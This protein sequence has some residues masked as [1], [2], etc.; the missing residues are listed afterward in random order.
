MKNIRATAKWIRNSQ[1]EIHNHRGHHVICD[2]PKNQGGDN[3][4]PTA[5]EL[6]TMALAGCAVSI[7][8]DVCKQSK[9]KLNRLEV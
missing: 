8:T 9:I 6:A 1:M 5:L 3:T 7:F 2:L 4:G